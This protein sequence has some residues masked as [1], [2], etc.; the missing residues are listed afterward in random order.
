[1]PHI[2]GCDAPQRPQP[3]S[4]T[5]SPEE[6]PATAN[7][8]SCFS[9][10]EL[11]QRAQ[12]AGESYRGTIFSKPCPQSL[13]RYSKIGIAFPKDQ[14]LDEPVSTQSAMKTFVSPSVFAFRLDPQTSFFPSFV[15]IGNPSNPSSKVTC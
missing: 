9:T 10:F 8:D 4:D 15:N 3:A 7:T 12:L 1:M 14:S 2:P 11:S 5:S 6:D 13:Q